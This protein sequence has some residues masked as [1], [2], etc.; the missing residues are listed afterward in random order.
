MATSSIGVVLCRLAAILLFVRA[1]VGVGHTIGQLDSS[2]AGPWLI[3]ST[4]F[5]VAL[6]PAA[7]GA[8]IW[9]YSERIS[10]LSPN[11]TESA[12]NDAVSPADLVMVGSILIGLYAAISGIV[13]GLTVEAG[14][15]ALDAQ[16][17]NQNL[18][19][20]IDT[21]ARIAQ[22]I[23]YTAQLVL[24]LLLVFGRKKIA[25]LLLKARRIGTSSS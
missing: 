8:G 11:A 18:A 14:Y 2:Y 24:G 15:W 4:A 9:I 23:P 19:D 13:H 6:V 17:Q 1:A 12:L 7:I 22:R 16:S 5:F 3:L 10:R 20:H 21:T 25:L